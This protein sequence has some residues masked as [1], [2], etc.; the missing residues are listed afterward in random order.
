MEEGSRELLGV[1]TW[2]HDLSYS[3]G[4]APLKMYRELQCDMGPYRTVCTAL[5]MF[6]HVLQVNMF[7]VCTDETHTNF[8]MLHMSG[9]AVE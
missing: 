9:L 3:S 7:L 8:T 6:T 2:Y 5:Y 4:L 1:G